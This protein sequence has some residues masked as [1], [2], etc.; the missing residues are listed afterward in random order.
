MRVLMVT[1]I[2]GVGKSTL[3]QKLSLLLGLSWNDYADL[4]SEL[5][6][7]LHFGLGFGLLTKIICVPHYKEKYKNQFIQI[8]NLF[9]KNKILL[10]PDKMAVYIEGEKHI[11]IRG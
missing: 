11:K 2:C 3:T 8:K 1:G 7:T 10:I 4:M 6:K 9:P 5:N